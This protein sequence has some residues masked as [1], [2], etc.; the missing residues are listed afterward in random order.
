MAKPVKKPAA[1]NLE[2]MLQR[3]RM[4]NDALKRLIRALE[5]RTLENCEKLKTNKS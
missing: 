2:E 1:E 3:I 5:I 4:E